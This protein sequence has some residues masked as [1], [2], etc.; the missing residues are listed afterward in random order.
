MHNVV[1]S[2]LQTCQR[3]GSSAVETCSALPALC[4]CAAI[5]IVP[6]GCA[7]HT[8][9]CGARTSC[10][11]SSRWTR[12]CACSHLARLECSWRAT[13]T[14]CAGVLV[15]IKMSYSTRCACSGCCPCMR[16]RATLG[17]LVCVFIRRHSSYW[18]PMTASI[19]IVSPHS[20][21]THR[22]AARR[23]RVRS[24]RS[25]HHRLNG[26]ARRARIGRTPFRTGS[27]TASRLCFSV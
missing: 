21:D 3:T 1:G 19:L 8:F 4:C 2:T 24:Y 27:C 23:L 26:S 5:V 9:I 10:R 12:S 25:V 11:C 6:S 15:V 17:A 13:H 14:F 18:A 7:G 20:R 16:A 22:S